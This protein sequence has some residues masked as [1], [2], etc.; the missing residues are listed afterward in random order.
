[1]VENKVRMVNLRR[2]GEEIRQ[3]ILDNVHSHPRDIVTFTAER[4][5]LTHQAVSKHIKNLIAQGLLNLK[6][7]TKDRY[8]SLT[9]LTSS[10]F[11]YSLD[12]NLKEDV[13]WSR[14]MRPLFSELHDNVVRIWQHGITEIINNA[15]DHSAGTLVNVRVKKT[16]V[17]SEVLI[18]DDGVGIFKKIARELNLEDERHAVLELAKG[19]VTTDPRHHSGE[20]IFFTSRMFDYFMI[21]SN[22]IMFSHEFHTSTDLAGERFMNGTEGTNVFLQ[23]KNNSARTIKQVFD[24]FSSGDFLFSKTVVPVWLAQYGSD[25]L[26]S[27]SQAKRLLAGIEKFEIV[28]L[29]FTNVDFIGQG[30]ADEIFRVFA[31]YHP[32]ITVERI[33]ANRDIEDMV[34][35]V[36]HGT[37]TSQPELF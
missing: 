37:D 17:T 29:D 30:F 23:I 26:V 6:G 19:K 13:V 10:S 12:G 27:R 7:K 16:A 28:V 24:E 32:N 33:N 22:Q 14:D 21:L 8:Y 31:K 20:G 15:I 25:R 18:W 36:R 9:E 5:H 34:K 3:F 4:F 35:R 2:K 11:T 1:M